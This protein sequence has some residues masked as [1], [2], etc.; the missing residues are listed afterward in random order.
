MGI[1]V[2]GSEGEI[3]EGGRFALASV[4]DPMSSIGGKLWP[5]GC[6]ARLVKAADL[7]LS[8]SFSSCQ[9]PSPLG[10]GWK[11][12]DDEPSVRRSRALISSDAGCT[13][14]QDQTAVFEGKEL[15]SRIA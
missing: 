12:L 11:T 5:E 6:Q 15:A 2:S 9:L 14:R 13:D 8:T 3:S 1:Q 4:W 7:L 10:E